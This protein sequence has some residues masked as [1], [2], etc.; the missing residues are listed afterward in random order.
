MTSSVPIGE[1]SRLCHLSTKTLRYY[2]DIEL[3]VP[4]GIDPGTGYRRYSTDQVADAH[5]IR[6]LRELSMPLVDIRSVL[7]APDPVARDDA[8]TAHLARMEAELARTRD[9]VLSLRRLLRAPADVPIAYRQ[10]P[11]FA[12]VGRE[13]RL[14]RDEVAG[15]CA[16]TYPALAATLADVGLEPAGPAGATYG[17]AF[18]E[19]DA[20][21]VLA[22]VPVAIDPITIDPVPGDGRFVM[23]PRQRFAVALHTGPFTDCDLTYGHL[24]G[25]VAAHEVGLREPIRE[26]YLVGPDVT[27]DPNQF[28]T[29]I[30]WPIAHTR[31]TGGDA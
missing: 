7:A 18:F 3:L 12:A 21:A 6:R 4:A 25:H 24:G 9:V 29:E 22:Y 26:I 5:L 23:L 28:Q 16:E 20:G 17:P 14:Q 31:T 8:L 13:A 15:W 11:A 19:E 1:F 30:C 2:H 27:D 10:S